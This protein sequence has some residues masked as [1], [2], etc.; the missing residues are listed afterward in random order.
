VRCVV[1]IRKLSEEG[2]GRRPGYLHCLILKMRKSVGDGW[3]KYQGFICNIEA[4]SV[5]IL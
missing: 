2:Q 5:D 1:E 4:A 3:D